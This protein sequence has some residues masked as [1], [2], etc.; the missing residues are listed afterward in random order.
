MKMIQNA[1]QRFEPREGSILALGYF[2]SYL[3]GSNEYLNHGKDLLLKMFFDNQHE[4]A[5][6]L[7]TSIGQLARMTCFDSRDRLNVKKFI[8]MIKTKIRTINETN[9]IKEKAIQ[10]LGFLAVCYRE[11][12]ENIIDILTQSLVDTKQIELQLNIGK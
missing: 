9:R 3:K 10:T 1:N 7:L 4:Y 5:L 8:E 2:C 12:S 11:E 6:A